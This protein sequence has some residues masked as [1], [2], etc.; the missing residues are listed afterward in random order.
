MVRKYWLVILTLI[1]LVISGC[2]K[3]LSGEAKKVALNDALAKDTPGEFRYFSLEKSD[4]STELTYSKDFTFIFEEEK[5][6]EQSVEK[7]GFAGIKI[8]K[9][10]LTVG[11]PKEPIYGVSTSGFYS[12]YGETAFIRVV[13]VDSEDVEWL[14]FG[15]DLL[16]LDGS[17]DFQNI[18]DETCAFDNPVEV[19]EIRVEGYN[20]R[21]IL[22][23]FDFLQ[24]KS[25]QDFDELRE[26][27]YSVKLH[28]LQNK[29][30]TKDLTWQ[31]GETSISKLL[32]RDLKKK[33]IGNELANLNGF[34]Y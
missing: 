6:W 3:D 9:D 16:F 18:C 11:L 33:F 15:T 13:L 34:Q 1:V 29:I 27:Q 25:R 5:E 23:S 10:I 8:K 20:A 28:V 7:D 14:I 21:I 24:T 31:A 19:K 4:E 2:N 17:A 26:E 22:D 12:L 32:Y 30:Q